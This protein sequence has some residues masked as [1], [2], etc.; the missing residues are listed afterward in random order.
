MIEKTG[1][2]STDE[3]LEAILEDEA[4]FRGD[5]PFSDD[6]TQLILKRL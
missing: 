2:R 4:K 6:V 5:A 3:I 1:H